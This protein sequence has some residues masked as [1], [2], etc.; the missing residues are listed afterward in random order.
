MNIGV[1]AAVTASVLVA[2]GPEVQAP[3]VPDGSGRA[4]AASLPAVVEADN[5]FAPTSGDQ[6]IAGDAPGP[7]KPPSPTHRDL[8]LGWSVQTTPYN[9]AVAVGPGGDVATLASRELFLH[10]AANGAVQA[11]VDVCFTF[12]G[13]LGFLDAETVAVVCEDAI[14]LYGLPKLEYRG[15]RSLPRA[16]SV[17]AFAGDTI[18]VAFTTGPML[19]LVAADL[20]NGK[21]LASDGTVTALALSADGKHLA[22]GLEGGDV[23]LHDLEAATK[24][25]WSIKRGHDVN[26]VAI[27]PAS[28]L[29]FAAAGPAVGVWRSGNR[30]IVRQFRSIRSADAARFTGDREVVVAGRDGVLRLSVDSGAVSS[31]ASFAGPD[32]HAVAL[33]WSAQSVL[34]AAEQDGRVGCFSRGRLPRGSQLMMLPRGHDDI[35]MAGRMAGRNGKKLRVR[36]LPGAP[37]PRTGDEALLLKYI[38]TTAGPVTSSEWRQLATVSVTNI[39]SDV[40]HVMLVGSEAVPVAH[41]PNKDPLAYDT[42]VKLVWSH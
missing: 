35:R 32:A 23:V 30:Q 8:T 15:R 19:L 21:E 17:A 4:D 38:E 31:L 20:Q 29:L 11:Q 34:C 13:A 9:K 37:L 33:D 3:K 36:A 7:A 28:R 42:P 6:A 22:V 10:D 2:C 41:D 5:D 18:A 12:P 40:V 16:A 24:E 27:S 1:W 25:R 26:A 39:E 14:S